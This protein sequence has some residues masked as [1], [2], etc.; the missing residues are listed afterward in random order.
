M[1]LSLL[2]CVLTIIATSYL[3]AQ[4]IQT[5]LSVV[6][7]ADI[8]SHL[9]FGLDTSATDLRDS[10]MGESEKP[11]HP[12][13]GMHAL[14]ILP[15]GEMCYRD[16]RKLF[17]VPTLTREF[18]VE[19]QPF[20]AR[21]KAPI[22]FKWDYPLE[23][24]IDS[25]IIYDRKTEGKKVRFSLDTRRKFVVYDDISDSFIIQ[26]YYSFGPTDVREDLVKNDAPF[27]NP[28][29]NYLFI[30]GVAKGDV[31]EISTM[32]GQTYSLQTTDD[33]TAYV[34]E[35]PAGIYSVAVIGTNGKRLA[36]MFV[37]R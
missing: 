3:P 15:S 37:K 31:L 34:S 35:L 23:K 29:D 12:P 5:V 7:V 36:G 27:P 17:A 8:G 25:I 20:A 32:N 14:F 21:D 26:A 19:V 28:A 6:D 18:R 30:Q 4:H 2:V 33:N 9:Y 22:N 1:K 10:S 24:G 13:G 16:F 11:G